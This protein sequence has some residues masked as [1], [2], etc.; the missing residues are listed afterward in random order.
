M[1]AARRWVLP[2]L[3]VLTIEAVYLSNGKTTLGN[4][5]TVPARYL[6]FSL[7]REGN[8]DFNEFQFLFHGLIA[9]T[10]FREVHGRFFSIFTP[11]A[12]LL[13]TPFYAVPILAG[14]SPESPW[15]A[16]LEKIAASTITALSALFLFLLLKGVAGARVATGLTAVYAFGTSAFS[17][18]SQALWQHGP[19]QLLLTLG[20][21]LL[22][23]AGRNRSLVAYAAFS[24]AAAV[25]A[26]YTNLLLLLPVSWYVVRHHRP[27]VWRCAGGASLPFLAFGTYNLL[28]F[29][30]PFDVSYGARVLSPGA[31]FWSAPMGYALAGL[32]VS[33]ISG[34]FVY[35]PIFAFSLFG[36]ALVWRSPEWALW[37][38]LAVGSL[39]VVLLTSQHNLWWSYWY[40]GPRLLSD[41]APILVFFLWPAWERIRGRWYLGGPFIAAAAISVLIQI[42]GVYG[43]DASWYAEPVSMNANRVWSWRGSPIPFYGTLMVRRGVLAIHTR[44]MGE[45]ESR[46]GIGGVSASIDVSPIPDVQPASG[47]LL[48]RVIL[49]NTGTRIWSPGSAPG[50]V[51]VKWQWQLGGREVAEAG[52]S[53]ALPT[54][55]LPGDRREAR[56]VIWPPSSP[57]RYTLRIGVVRQPDLWLADRL[58]PVQ[59]EGECRFSR[60]MA[61]PLTS[62]PDPPSLEILSH[63]SVYRPEEFATFFVAVRNGRT[64]RNLALFIALRSPDGRWRFLFSNDGAPGDGSCIEWLPSPGRLTLPPGFRF[65]DTLPL[66]LLLHG[67]PPGRYEWH[68]AL[69]EPDSA[70][71]VARASTGFDLAPE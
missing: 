56:P 53:M 33:P 44:L 64:L 7:M 30:S 38:C 40:Y 68:A 27:D 16:H 24:L 1:G 18:S 57:S 17:I 28:I 19:S 63:A 34:L 8:F 69:L 5:D 60:V 12:G 21:Y 29:G 54:G 36:I 4:I 31:A 58:A 2:L 48:A 51:L 39:L 66:K 15:V 45:R 22:V 32:L 59:V 23:K 35:S 26:R 9:P 61:G 11:V 71:I 62:L 50:S 70:R 37:R 41:L 47:P 13:A 3:I 67:R 20:L 14:L 42:I 55:T 25:I 49:T 52:G 6:P 10:V 46:D 43:Y 65:D